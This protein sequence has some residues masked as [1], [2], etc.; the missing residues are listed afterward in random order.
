M[1]IPRSFWFTVAI[2]TIYLLF[3]SSLL[4]PNPNLS[5]TI[6]SM[7]DTLIPLSQLM[8]ITLP[9]LGFRLSYWKRDSNPVGRLSTNRRLRTW[10]PLIFIMALVCQFV[11]GN[12][13]AYYGANHIFVFPSWADVA[14]LATYPTLLIG[15]LCFPSRSLSGKKR[16]SMLLSSMLVIVGLVTFSW[17][18]LL[19]PMLLNNRGESLLAT[20]AHL[21]F[22]GFDLLLICYI[23]LFIITATRGPLRLT[24][25]LLSVALTIF[26]MTDS[27]FQYQ[28]LHGS[29]VPGWYM[30]GWIVGNFLIALA[31]QSMRWVPASITTE[32]ATHET[33]T[34]ATSTWQML[35]PYALVPAVFG[36]AF[37]IWGIDRTSLL[38]IGTYS[39]CGL[40]LILIFAKQVVTIREI[41]WLNDKLHAANSRLEELA[42]T[43]PLTELPNHRALMT[44]LTHEL[45]RTQRYQRS[46]SLLFFDIDHFKALNDGYGHTT[47]DEALVIFGQRL[48]QSVRG[49]DIV[50]RWGGEE[51]VAILPEAT[52]QEASEVA[53][54]IR[55]TISLQPFAIAGGLFITCSVGVASYPSHA[56]TL[57]NLIEAADQAMYAAKRLGRNQVRCIDEPAVQLMLNSEENQGGR[58]E[59]TIKGII[60]ALVSLIEQRDAELGDHAELVA[61][62]VK[63]LA[64]HLGVPIKEAQMMQLAGKLHDIGKIG[65]SDAILQKP[66]QL[67]QEEWQQ[68][69]KHSTAGAEIVAY[70]PA[71]RPL[72][73]VIRAHHERWDGAGYPNQLSRENIPLA[74]RIIAVVDAYTA[75][76][77]DR[78]YQSARSSAE[79]L[80]ELQ[81]CAGTQFDPTVVEALATLLTERT[82]GE[83]RAVQAA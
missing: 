15:M 62:L 41:R 36:L 11:G 25:I 73:P 49:I 44:T 60:D 21:A 79:A 38:A 9:W 46:C 57:N 61:E 35:L 30:I 40:L 31:V 6:R 53:E 82:H 55:S 12:L 17:Y 76:I 81:R 68:M 8:S 10:L 64:I 48:R 70:I 32:D 65:I 83:E 45:E 5:S 69:K 71:L 58:E 22:P 14:I 16:A 1:S 47:G 59:A 23:V 66:A 63:R 26:T 24:A 27:V 50:G 29:N 54:R 75:M 56:T 77:V 51:F 4:I 37:Y 52:P 18:F 78:P 43:D 67:T 39:G 72:E 19:G 74:A 7:I 28:R 20:I 13:Y 42:T 33:S 80:K 34:R 2:M 3:T